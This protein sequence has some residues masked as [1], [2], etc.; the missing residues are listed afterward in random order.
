MITEAGF[1]QL[2]GWVNTLAGDISEGRVISLLEGG[3]NLDALER[4]VVA[5]LQ[6]LS[7]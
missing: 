7:A 5:H 6:E 1:A 3:Y 2:T 4:S